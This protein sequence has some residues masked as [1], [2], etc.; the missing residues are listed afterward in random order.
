[1]RSLDVLAVSVWVLDRFP[2]LPPAV[3]SIG[4][5]DGANGCLPLC[6]VAL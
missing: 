2:F 4:V 1:M 5:R 6:T 3:L